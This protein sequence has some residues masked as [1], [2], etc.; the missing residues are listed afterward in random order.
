MRKKSMR[1]SKI[2]IINIITAILLQLFAV[3]SVK[4]AD[5]TFTKD[6]FPYNIEFQKVAAGDFFSVAIDKEGYLWTWGNDF[7]HMYSYGFNYYDQNYYDYST[8][9]GTSHSVKK[10]LYTA[11][12]SNYAKGCLGDGVTESNNK[13]STA[14]TSG[15][16]CS[17]YIRCYPKK[18]SDVKFIDVAAGD[19]HAFA[20]DE[21]GYL[22]GWGNN[23]VGQL[24]DGTL[25]NKYVPTPIMGSVK[26]SKISTSANGVAAVD[27][28]GDVWT[29]GYDTVYKG[30]TQKLA[31][32]ITT[33]GNFVDASA[34]TNF[35][36]AI[37]KDGNLWGAGSNY[38]GYLGSGSTTSANITNE[39]K[40]I[41]SGTNFVKIAS[42]CEHT[43]AIDKDGYL[44]SWGENT[45]GQLGLGS[46]EDKSSPTLVTSYTKFK[47]I[48]T[49]A[50]SNI[51]IDVDGNIW[52]WGRNDYGEL[53]DGSNDNKTS[54]T[55]VKRGYTATDV[56]IS[57]SHSLILLSNNELWGAS[58]YSFKSD[59]DTSSYV[60]K[61][62]QLGMNT[63]NTTSTFIQITGAKKE[64]TVTFKNGT[65]TLSTQTILQGESA[66]LPSPL[67]TKAGYTLSW[68]TDFSNVTSDLTVNAVWT[69]NTNI[70]YTVEHY[71]Q[72]TD[73]E[74]VGYTL[75]ETENKTGA[76]DS[77]ALAVA[78]TYPGFTENKTYSGRVATGT[79]TT[80]GSLVLKLYYDRNIYNI[81]YELDGGTA[82]GTLTSTY[83]YGKGI[84]LST[85]VAKDGYVFG[86]WYDNSECSGDDVKQIT[87]TDT[88]D[89]TFFAKWLKQDEFYL[90]SNKHTVETEEKYITKISPNTNVQ[91]FKNNMTTNGNVKILNSKREEIG[92]SDLV[93]T[94]H[95]LQVEFNG[96]THE[97]QLVVKGDID[98]NGKLSVTDLAMVNQA[99]V[100]RITL[101]GPYSK[102]SDLDSNN[103]LSVTD[104]A[105]INQAIVGRITL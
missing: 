83:M 5:Q 100:G 47:E 46:L 37:D 40:L 75:F 3:Q 14:T 45:Y 85:K 33:T 2:L 98:G 56:S 25:E 51:A 78:K 94:G 48:K 89:K 57:P 64:F 27:I 101:Q 99:I 31:T 36:V 74:V 49:N 1:V 41:K 38:R 29:W 52:S 68:D 54:P 15:G 26:F 23:Y 62:P 55:R 91:T 53:G 13:Y 67:P 30:E 50:Y 73:S 90:T 103:K 20:I 92:S 63:K 69:A 7:R 59:D 21:E 72:T 6:D 95:I 18:I 80:D 32:K 34:G 22:W 104:L 4:A 71:Q 66:I 24:G 88:G 70:P 17:S 97:Y 76:T 35:V 81:N 79:V 10:M 60:L 11:G 8:Y 42:G 12:T 84:S 44:W 82:T 102:A 43:I 9:N 19:S 39:F 65:E 86:G 16:Y 87:S 77:L 93:G 58:T 105:M 28:S 61:S 96:T